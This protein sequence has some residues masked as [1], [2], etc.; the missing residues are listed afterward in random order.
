[1]VDECQAAGVQAHLAEPADVAGLKGRRQH[2]K[3]DRLDARHLRE[4]LEAG[5][6]PEC[7]VPP[8]HVLE[9]RAKVRLYKDLLEERSGWQQRVHATLF[10]LGAPA[11]ARR[12]DSDPARLARLDA[13]SP[14]TRQA[15]SVALRKRCRASH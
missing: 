15:T 3:T 12:L 10:H 8:H 2:P 13:L 11:Q 5:K 9:I 4:L 1:V 6:L 14:A 7:W